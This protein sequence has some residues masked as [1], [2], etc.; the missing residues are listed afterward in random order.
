[1]N[2]SSR[3]PAWALTVLLAVFLSGCSSDNGDSDGAT[4]TR[5]SQESETA[6]QPTD[7][8]VV[9]AV[10]LRPDDLPSGYGA[11]GFGEHGNLVDGQVTMGMCGATFA[12]EDLRTARHQVGYPGPDDEF[13]SSETVRYEPGGAQQAMGEL[14]DAVANCPKGFVRS[15]VAGEPPYKAKISQ[16]PVDADWQDDTVALRITYTPKT[17]PSRSGA[18]IY[19]RLDDTIAAVYVFAGAETSP[20]L[21]AGFASLVSDRLEAAAPV[22]GTAS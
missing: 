20:G 15:D 1:M 4:P 10:E 19:Q 18:L 13:I 16:L 8:E 12:S 5:D 6:L 14:R 9:L 7:E 11:E 22:A 2:R 17:G 3:R 21:A